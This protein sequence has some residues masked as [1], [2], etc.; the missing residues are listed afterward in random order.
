[1]TRAIAVLGYF[2]KMATMASNTVSKHKADFWKIRTVD[3]L[4]LVSRDITSGKFTVGGLSGTI[5]AWKIVDDELSN[6]SARNV[7]E[8]VLND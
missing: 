5:T 1:M 7:L 4:G 3:V 2:L 8:V 6:A